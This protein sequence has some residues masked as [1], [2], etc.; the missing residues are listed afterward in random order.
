MVGTTVAGV[1]RGRL[2]ARLGLLLGAELSAEVL[3]GRLAKDVANACLD[4]GLV[5]NG[6][7][8]TAIRFA[9]RSISATHTCKKASGSSPPCW[10]V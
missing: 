4:A 5:V 6:V 9:P 8:N 10:R 1:A 3:D 7:T 2:C